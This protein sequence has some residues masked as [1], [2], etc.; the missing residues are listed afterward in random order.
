MRDFKERVAVV[1]GAG[2]GIGRAL[3]QN[4][5]R[6]GAHL[7]L[8]DVNEGA[9]T[10]TAASI[11]TGGGKV[12]TEIVD[13]ADRE[14]MEAHAAHVVEAH[15]RANLVIN[16][17]GV[18]VGASVADHK[19]ED[20]QWLMGINFWGVV[21]GTQ[22]FLPHLRASG[23]GHVVNISSVFGIISVPDQSSY[24]ASKFAVRGF[25]E[26]LRQELEIE[27]APVS[28]TCV[29]P[30]GI[31]TNIARDARMVFG[32]MGNVQTHEEA[33]AEFRRMARHSPEKA[34]DVILRGV[35]RNKRRVLIGPEAYVIDW[36]QRLLPTAYQKI[37]IWT[38][39]RRENAS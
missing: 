34:A 28:A 19:P 2:S 24:N 1:T 9:L 13:V 21:H 37:L 5:A 8:S 39:R 33:D 4:L 20:F 17:A 10:E 18:T 11:P 31:Q 14:A 25:T 36:V 15:G 3:A 26:S 38:A 35:Q 6:Q 30:G 27:G 22:A 29:H 16:N 12:T 32:S 7:A 23:E